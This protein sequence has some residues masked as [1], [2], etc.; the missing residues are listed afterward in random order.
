MNIFNKN[1]E[2]R[3]IKNAINNPNEFRYLYELY[4]EKIYKFIVWR[5]RTKEDAE[6]LTSQTFL[7]ALDKL[8]TFNF[9]KNNS[10]NSWIFK[11][12]HNLIVDFYRGDN[13]NNDE[14]SVDVVPDD[15]TSS[16]EDEIAFNELKK[17]IAQLP[18]NQAEVLILS[19][20]HEMKNKEI[21]QILNIKERSVSS[22]LSRAKNNLKQLVTN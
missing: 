17:K 14:I 21:A 10:L 5:V 20:I 1:N 9:K 4:F 6:D 15:H 2:A 13:R 7:K 12:A 22:T 19:V 16:L 11:I 8:E 3:L 18:H